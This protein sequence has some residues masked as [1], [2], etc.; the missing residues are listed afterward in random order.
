MSLSKSEIDL[1]EFLSEYRKCSILNVEKQYLNVKKNFNFRSEEY[2]N[3]FLDKMPLLYS[4]LVD[5]STDEG[6]IRGIQLFSLPFLYRF[7]S[8]EVQEENNNRP[9][10]QQICKDEEELKSWSKHYNNGLNGMTIL[11]YGCGSASRSLSFCRKYNTKAILLDI[12]SLHLDFA[13][14]RFNKYNI[15]H[16]KIPITNTNLYTS[17]PNFNFCIMFNI[18]EHIRQP[19]K[20]LNN[21]CNSLSPEGCLLINNIQ[22]QQKKEWQHLSEDM[23]EARNWLN[24]NMFKVNNRVFR[25]K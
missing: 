25:K 19:K 15:E 17:L 14:W 11:D 3:Y 24:N 23:I 9:L 22:H 12:D 7:I 18:I 4:P 20:V 2:R 13:S 21:I 1:I 10:D 6:I 8:Y 16:I 5:S